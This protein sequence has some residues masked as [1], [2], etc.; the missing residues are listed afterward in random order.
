MSG[1]FRC[2]AFL[3]LN[4][5]MEYM[6]YLTTCPP[7]SIRVLHIIIY[8]HFVEKMSSRFELPGIIFF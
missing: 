1:E 3:K 5:S 2:T 6:Q 4:A 8:V 7:V